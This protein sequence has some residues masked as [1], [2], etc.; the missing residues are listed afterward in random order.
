VTDDEWEQKRQRVIMAV[1]QTGRPVF[2]DTDGEMRYVDGDREELPD[3]VGVARAPLPR[4]TPT[5]YDKAM[6]ASGFAYTSSVVAAAIN[7]VVGLWHPWYYA[8]A[9]AALLSALVWRRVHHSQRKLYG[10]R[11]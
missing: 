2:A 9:V 5:I 11:R 3:D 7:A 4:A 8:F 6:R 10:A 1:F